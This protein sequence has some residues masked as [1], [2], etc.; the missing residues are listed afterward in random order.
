VYWK[1]SQIFNSCRKVRYSPFINQRQS[2]YSCWLLREWKG[3]ILSLTQNNLMSSWG[4]RHWSVCLVQLWLWSFLTTTVDGLPFLRLLVGYIV[5]MSLWVCS[6]QLFV[7]RFN[8]MQNAT[9]MMFWSCMHSS[10]D[11]DVCG[12]A[13]LLHVAWRPSYLPVWF[14]V[15]LATSA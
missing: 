14:S 6:L 2:L 3:T 12:P 7:T 8:V 11:L 5:A 1:C 10:H 4:W 9:N 13:S 15:P